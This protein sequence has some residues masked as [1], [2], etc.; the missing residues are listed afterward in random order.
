MGEVSVTGS[1]GS[2]LRNPVKSVAVL[3]TAAV[4]THVARHNAAVTNVTRKIENAPRFQ[5][6]ERCFQ[7]HAPL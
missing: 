2:V 3:E 4:V 5:I 6:G 1:C 7:D